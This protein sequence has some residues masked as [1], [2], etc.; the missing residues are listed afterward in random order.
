MKKLFAI[1]I[2][3]AAFA[4]TGCNTVAGFGKDVQKVGQKMEGAGSK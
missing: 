2:A 3:I 4:L 1:A